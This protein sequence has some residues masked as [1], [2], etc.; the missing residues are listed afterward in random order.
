MLGP[1]HVYWD[2]G[3]LAF[4][5]RRFPGESVPPETTLDWVTGPARFVVVPERIADMEMLR[6]LYPGGT[7]TVLPGVNRNPLVLIYDWPEP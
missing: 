3:T 4:M 5:L 1:P 6:D 2:F 7:E